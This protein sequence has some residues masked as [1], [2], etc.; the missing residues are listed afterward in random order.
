MFLYHIIAFI[1]Y[2]QFFDILE[3]VKL[4][5]LLGINEFYSKALNA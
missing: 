4:L 5:C 2:N 3:M 1:L